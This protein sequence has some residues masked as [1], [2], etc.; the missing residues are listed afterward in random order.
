MSGSNSRSKY[1][2]MDDMSNCNS[3]QGNHLVTL[4][5]RLSM[6]WS[7]PRRENLFICSSNSV[8]LGY[9]TC[10]YEGCDGEEMARMKTK[11]RRGIFRL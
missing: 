5:S 1:V 7:P 4:E 8:V 6:A 3:R 10:R 11:G 9:V 2:Y